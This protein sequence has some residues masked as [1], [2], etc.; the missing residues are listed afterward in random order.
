MAE[1]KKK[2]KAGLIILPLVAGAGAILY[3]LTRKTPVDP[4]KAVLYGQVTDLETSNGIKD[5]VVNCGGYTGKSGS[6]GG[7]QIINIPP[8]T[9]PVTFTHPSYYPVEV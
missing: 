8:G 6:D 4:E 1:E 9:Y 2:R 3:F 7:Y 5:A